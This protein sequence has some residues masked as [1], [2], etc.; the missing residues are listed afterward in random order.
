MGGACSM[1][2]K[3]ESCI[4]G[5]GGGPKERDHLEDLEVNGRTI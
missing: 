1:Y 5:F 3:Q 2:G 4:H